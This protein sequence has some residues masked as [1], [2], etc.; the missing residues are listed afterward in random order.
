VA[1]FDAELYLRVAG[2]QVDRFQARI[3]EYG[4]ACGYDLC[5]ITAAQVAEARDGAE[6]SAAQVAGV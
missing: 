4:A 6:R 2:E 1:E 3:A 5:L